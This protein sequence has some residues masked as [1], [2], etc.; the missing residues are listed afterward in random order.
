M[1]WGS[2][3]YGEYIQRG[4]GR[5]GWRERVLAAVAVAVAVTVAVT[6]IPWEEE[7]LRRATGGPHL[8][9]IL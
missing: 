5:K 1:S 2:P 4:Y 3:V 6:A 7:R 8:M 9:P